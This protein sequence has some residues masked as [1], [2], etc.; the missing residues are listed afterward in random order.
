MKNKTDLKYIGSG[1]L[2]LTAAFLIYIYT[3]NIN[4]LGIAIIIICSL[5]IIISFLAGLSSKFRKYLGIR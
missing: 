1:I 3:P 5:L 4:W 2:F